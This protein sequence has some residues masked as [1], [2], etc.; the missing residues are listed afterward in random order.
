[1]KI[2]KANRV[3]GGVLVMVTAMGT[4]QTVNTWELPIRSGTIMSTTG[5]LVNDGELNF[6][7]VK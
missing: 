3:M 1:M 7:S 6:K 4:A 2:V 5:D